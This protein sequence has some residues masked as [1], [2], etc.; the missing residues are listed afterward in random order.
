MEIPHISC[1][2]AYLNMIQMDQIAHWAVNPNN[3]QIGS[4]LST[5]N[6]LVH[7]KI[8]NYLLVTCWKFIK[9]YYF[10]FKIANV[11]LLNYIESF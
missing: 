10:L 7:K 6:P 3:I 4:K 8:I 5:I 11:P 1:F 9:H 2:V